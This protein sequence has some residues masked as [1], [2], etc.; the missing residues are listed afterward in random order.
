[1]NDLEIT[2]IK[3]VEK[4][5]ELSQ[6]LTENDT[7]HLVVEKMSLIEKFNTELN[8]RDRVIDSL[9]IDLDKRRVEIDGLDSDLTQKKNEVSTLTE[10]IHKMDFDMDSLR[11]D[12]ETRV[13]QKLSEK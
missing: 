5:E 1:M 3:L 9:N 12:L 11:Q 2:I 10:Q 13:N 6:A 7:A 8:R 4:N